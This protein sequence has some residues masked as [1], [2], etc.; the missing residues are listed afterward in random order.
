MKLPND[1]VNYLRSGAPRSGEL[2]DFP[3]W[4][5]IWPEDQMKQ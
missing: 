5:E 4:F 1:F 2:P 3:L